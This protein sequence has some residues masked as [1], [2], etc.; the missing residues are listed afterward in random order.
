MSYH[1]R[2]PVRLCLCLLHNTC[3]AVCC[4]VSVCC[5]CGCGGS[6]HSVQC[7]LYTQQCVSGVRAYIL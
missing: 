3:A 4:C 6:H 2:L 5:V 7:T 1:V